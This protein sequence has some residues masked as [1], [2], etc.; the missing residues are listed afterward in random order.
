MRKKM[1]VVADIGRDAGKHYLLTEMPA[2]VAEMWAFDAL[3]LLARSGQNVESIDPASGMAGIAVAGLNALLK[4]DTEGFKP[5]LRQ[6]FDCVQMIPDPRNPH[7]YRPLVEDD[8]EEVATRIWL[9]SKIYELHVSFSEAGASSQTEA[10]ASQTS[11]PPRMIT[12]TRPAVSGRSS[13]VG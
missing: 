6:M 3:G 7:F 2:E 13:R 5:L 1:E 4:V 9:R 11:A 12:R 8:I 10:S